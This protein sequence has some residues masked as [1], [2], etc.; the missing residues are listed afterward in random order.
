MEIVL[1]KEDSVKLEYKECPRCHNPF[2]A[3]KRKKTSHHAL[4][5][6]L[7]PK[8]SIEINLCLECH[9]E[10]NSYYRQQAITGK[11]YRKVS[12]TFE[13]FFEN[14]ENL[15]KDYYD[16]KLNRGEFGEGLWSNLVTY[17][18]ASNINGKI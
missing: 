13:E 12:S 8:T 9:N 17:L 18:K 3:K 7:E 14:Y 4:P 11:K 1:N 5:S 2:N 16:K 10:L 6:F 15:R